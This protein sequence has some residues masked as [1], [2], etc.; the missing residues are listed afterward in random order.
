VKDGKRVVPCLYDHDLQA[1]PGPM[2]D[3]FIAL[4]VLLALTVPP[5]VAALSHVEVSLYG[6]FYFFPAVLKKPFIIDILQ[7]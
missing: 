7:K 1:A 2:R 6:Y 5:Y 4:Q 3:F